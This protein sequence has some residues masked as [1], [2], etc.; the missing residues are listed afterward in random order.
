MEY[1]QYF[2][3]SLGFIALSKSIVKFIIWVWASFLRPSKN[4]KEYYGAWVLITGSTDG[5]GKALAFELAAKGLN[6]ILVGRNP[7]KLEDTVNGINEKY[8]GK[9]SIRT[10]VIDFAKCRPDEIVKKIE[11][12][13]IFDDV[14][15]GILINNAGLSYP[16]AK[17]LHEV[18]LELMESLMKVNMV[19]LSCVTKSIIPRMLL[20]KKGAIVN[21]GSGS[22][23][24]VSSYPLYS[25]YAATK[26]YVQMLSKSLSIEYKQQGIDVQCQIPLLVATKMTYI[27]KSS[28]FIPSAEAY[29]KASIKWIGYDE[30]CMPYWP[31]AIQGFIIR[32]LPE[33]LV[34]QILFWYFNGM[35]KRGMH[36]DSKLAKMK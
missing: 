31:H 21:I 10:V 22:S 5:I 18:D 32:A 36:R 34:D 6:L 16:Y 23:S 19:G 15:V 29:S 20:K 14:D 11:E 4:L 30:I 12:E 33:K 24:T 27:K 7:T 28:L 35:R 3:L 9:I 17:Y 8:G 26:A 2:I 1:L 25:V 13:A